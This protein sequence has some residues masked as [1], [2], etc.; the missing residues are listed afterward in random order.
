[1]SSLYL[2]F[3]GFVFPESQNDEHYNCKLLREYDKVAEQ[4]RQRIESGT[5]YESGLLLDLL[6]L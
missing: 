5:F 6:T 2:Q 3:S 4:I 1:M